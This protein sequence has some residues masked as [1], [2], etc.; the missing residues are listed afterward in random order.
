MTILM[1]V[2]IKILDGGYSDWSP[3]GNCSVKCE[4]ETGIKV[5]TRTCNN[6]EPGEYGLDCAQQRLGEPKEEVEC[7]GETP[8]QILDPE[9]ECYEN[10]L[11]K[12]LVQ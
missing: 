11:S 12:F 3:F 2:P 7:Q 9:K 10:E 8:T 5:R 4:N 6:P 1:F